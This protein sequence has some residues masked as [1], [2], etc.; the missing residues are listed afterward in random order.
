MGKSTLIRV[1]SGLIKP[2]KGLIELMGNNIT[3]YAPHLRA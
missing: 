3:N 2:T 1:L